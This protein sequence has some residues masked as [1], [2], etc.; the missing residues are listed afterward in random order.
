MKES[1]HLICLIRNLKEKLDV[2]VI[3]V[4]N[5]QELRLNARRTKLARE[6]FHGWGVKWLVTA[7]TIVAGTIVRLVLMRLHIRCRSERRRGLFAAFRC[8]R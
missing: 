4:T 7:I 8:W 5:E 1:E 2:V 6:E 3:T